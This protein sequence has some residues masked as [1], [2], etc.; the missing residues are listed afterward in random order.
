M[1]RL[2]RPRN[3]ASFNN[4]YDNVALKN[5]NTDMASSRSMER[6]RKYRRKIANDAEWDKRVKKKDKQ[7]KRKG[8]ENM[9]S[10]FITDPYKR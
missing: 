7:H 9:K 8:R 3:L 5:N 4:S 2:S 6:T 10:T 1:E